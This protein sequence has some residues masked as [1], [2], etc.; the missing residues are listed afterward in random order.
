VGPKERTAGCDRPSLKFVT[1]E[2]ME[3]FCPAERCLTDTVAVKLPTAIE[4]LS[5]PQS[6]GVDRLPKKAVKLL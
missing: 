5:G 3:R 4:S 2:Q 1:A 6:M